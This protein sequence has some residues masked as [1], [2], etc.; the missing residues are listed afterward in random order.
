MAY[1]DGFYY[2]QCKLICEAESAAETG[3][4]SIYDGDRFINSKGLTNKVAEFTVPGRARYTVNLMRGNDTVYSTVVEAGY[5]DCIHV[6]LAPGYDKVT[7]KQFDSQVGDFIFEVNSDGLAGYRKSGADTF[8]PFKF[9]D[10]DS[11]TI[12]RTHT[13]TVRGL[14]ARPIINTVYWWNFVTDSTGGHMT[15]M[16]WNSG[17]GTGEMYGIIDNNQSHYDSWISTLGVQIFDDGFSLTVPSW[18]PC[19]MIFAAWTY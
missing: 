14:K 16:V 7:E 18:I 9:G 12:A 13:M 6:M 5:G 2:G 15:F 3:T 1:D 11:K 19:N 17:F 4:V 10:G 8:H